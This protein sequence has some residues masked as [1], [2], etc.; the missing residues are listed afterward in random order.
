MKKIRQKNWIF[1][2]QMT[3]I[4]QVESMSN[5]NKPCEDLLYFG[6]KV[7][8]SKLIIDVYL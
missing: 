6:R 3:T 7:F 5:N 2:W 8:I 4:I 1:F